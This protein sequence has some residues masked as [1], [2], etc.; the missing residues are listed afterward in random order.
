[1]GVGVFLSVAGLAVAGILTATAATHIP[2]RDPAA[3]APSIAAQAP[4]I[5]VNRV[6]KADRQ[7]ASSGNTIL[8]KTVRI[9]RPSETAAMPL[10]ELPGCEASVSSLAD[11]A[12]GRVA[13]HCDT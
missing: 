7:V 12:A 6:A 8:V 9:S 4:S 13:R 11:R 2:P 1:M 10:R 5:N 3:Q